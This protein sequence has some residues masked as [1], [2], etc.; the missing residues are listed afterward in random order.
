VITVEEYQA[1]EGKQV[2]VVRTNG[3]EYE[4]ESRGVLAPLGP[5]S[6]A[7][8]FTPAR[9]WLAFDVGTIAKLEVLN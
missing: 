4:G 9:E 6:D 5:V 2:R 3:R 8:L 7:L 1:T